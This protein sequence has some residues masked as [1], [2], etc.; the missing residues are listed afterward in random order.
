M[1]IVAATICGLSFSPPAV[2]APV[3]APLPTDS[4][5][6]LV[7]PSIPY[8]S[9]ITRTMRLLASSTP[10][11][12]HRVR[13]LFY[14]QSITG[15]WTDIVLKDL[16][17]RFPIADIVAAN[18]AIGGFQAPLLSQMAEEDLY[19]YYPDLLFLQDGGAQTP[20]RVDADRVRYYDAAGKLLR[21][22]FDDAAATALKSPLRFEF[23][24]N[25]VDVVAAAA[26]PFGTAKI[27]IDSKKPSTFHE[28]Y[29]MTRCSGAPN[30]YPAVRCVTLAEGVV[31][32][33]WEMT[34]LRATNDRSYFE[35]EV[36]GS[37]TG[38]DGKGDNKETFT[39]N[40]GRLIIEP[41][42]TSFDLGKKH[43]PPPPG[44]KAKW[45]VYGMLLD[46]WKP[47]DI[48]DPAKE[49]LYTLAQGLSNGKHVLEIVPNG[50]GELPVRYRNRK[51]WLPT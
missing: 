6:Y 39:S 8:G 46:E 29:A 16:R 37:V 38:L 17:R 1:S 41:K 25:S 30:G 14:G 47:Q 40:S 15:G 19:P 7:P 11:H 28:L 42:T 3:L 12:K 36:K 2:A 48:A 9:R 44:Y 18:R 50:D 10:E 13:I 27:L 5:R 43:V 4:S 34:I 45:S 32:E 24:G 20:A 23:E 49:N 33:D 31:A 21:G 51:C 35:F 26:G 22:S